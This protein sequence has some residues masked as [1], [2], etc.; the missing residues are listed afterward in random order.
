MNHP[1][2]YRR[3][4]LA[5]VAALLVGLIPATVLADQTDY[6]KV[7][8]TGPVV[9]G[10]H[11][12]ITV[13]AYLEPTFDTI[14]TAYNASVAFT[15]SDVRISAG[16]GLPVPAD[17]VW[18]AV[19]AGVC[20]IP[21]GVTFETAASQTVTV[22]EGDNNGTS[23]PVTV[24]H[25]VPLT[26]SILPTDTSITAGGTETYTVTG[27]DAFENSWV[28]TS[29]TEFS[30]TPNGTCGDNSCGSNTAG[31]HTVKAADH[32]HPTVVITTGLTVDPGG[33]DHLVITTSPTTVVAGSSHNYT[34]TAEDQYGNTMTSG[35]SSTVT[36]TSTDSADVMPAP[37]TLTNGVG[38]FAVTLKTAGSQ[39]VHAN[40][41]TRP[42]ADQTVTVDPGGVDHLVIT[43]SPTTVVAGSSHNYTVTAE[44]QYGN[45]MTSG[46]S[47]TVTLTST[48][49]ADVM[50][51]PATL[52]NGVGTFAVT[53]KTAG[54]QTV[55]ANDGTRPQADQTVTVDPGGVDHLV[56]T[57]S[58]TTVVAGSSHNYTVTAEDQYGNTMTSGYSSTVTISSTDG[59]AAPMPSPATLTA[60]IGF[61]S[62]TLNTPGTQ[63]VHA[64]DGTRQADQVVTVI[65][66]V[67]AA[68]L[69]IAGSATAATFIPQD[70]TVT[71]ETSLDAIVTG[72]TGDVTITGSDLTSAPT[73]AYLT[74]GVGH[75]AITF[76]ATGSQTVRAHDDGALV[77]TGLPV[78]VT[79]LGPATKFLVEVSGATTVAAGT[80]QSYTVTAQ[81]A[82]GRTVTNYAGIVH[83]TS[84]DGGASLPAN[85][86]L[87]AGV[88]V[89]SVTLQTAGTQSVTAT[90]TVTSSITGNGPSIVVTRVTSTYHPITPLRVLDTR[91]GNGMPGGTIAKLKAGSPLTLHVGGRLPIAL[92]ATAVTANVTIVRPGAASTVYLGPTAIAKPS[93]FTIAFNANDI[94][95]Y[96]VTVAL[97]PTGTMSA[98]YMAASGT[99]DLVMDI[100]G[101]FMA[102]DATGD[103][104][105]AI[106]PVRVLDNR[107]K[108]GLSGKFVANVPRE[109]QV[110][111]LG[112]PAGAKAV[113]GNVTVTG[114]TKSGALYLGPVKTATPT[115][116]TINF[117][118]GQVRANSLTVILS[119]TG[120]LSAVFLVAKGNTLDLVFDVTGYYTADLS[121]D[122]YVPITPVPL[123]DT[124][125]GNGLAGGTPAKAAANVPVTFTAWN[126]GGVPSDAAGV[127]GLVSVYNQSGGSAVFVGPLPIVKPTTS[128][129]NFVRTD[130][131][132]N[133]LTVALS[134][135]GTMSVTYMAVS[136]YSTNVLIYVTGY[137]VKP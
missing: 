116:S 70:Y 83:I 61:F 38:T 60:G 1:R 32:A 54:S 79:A 49:S 86:T 123:L 88:H 52:T 114:S 25:A 107:V 36:L 37:A 72:Y 77:A 122:K 31:E 58:P 57:T 59:A 131:S 90:D 78:T 63:T 55:H 89:F 110:R 41:G 130:N 9:A 136:G 84:S 64:N 45:T 19:T 62:V 42:Q 71:A 50:P 87:T 111:R 33:V 11:L 28:A 68:K 135:T 82:Y 91:N 127:T 106:T 24:T 129:L 3:F 43:T 69:V 30:I 17:C 137:F 6:F 26:L 10:D 14:D 93:T 115:T 97:S 102:N 96:G 22:T 29:T 35:Y 109:F 21:D 67:E 27:H 85:S 65:A 16:S 15:S 126:R 103:T 133:G 2:I 12:D 100:T 8:M 34:V 98:T 120:T 7:E 23:A 66:P 51:A 39:T 118:K 53:L 113:T 132:S 125:T 92:A 13:T 80:V 95:A 112:V 74:N 124:R 75:F 108:N 81:D 134:D 94:T 99:T 104:Y 4:A 5:A 101:Y 48:D 117:G 105:H 119:P 76:S 46:Y 121:G 73:H 18:G 44:D 40:D 20:S 56:I 128:A 47:S